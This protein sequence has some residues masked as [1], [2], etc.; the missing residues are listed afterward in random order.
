MV[1]GW[2]AILL[3]SVAMLVVARLLPAA[4]TFPSF[5]NFVPNLAGIALVLALGLAT[6]PYSGVEVLALRPPHWR[7]FPPVAVSILGITL[8]SAEL[9]AWLQEILPAPPWVLD[10]YRRVLEYDTFTEFM[11]V[12]VFL[13][14]VAPLTEELLFR[15]LFLHRLTEGY[16]RRLGI[17]ASALCFGIFHVLPWQAVTAALVGIYLGWLVVRTRSIFPSIFA[18][19]L[20][21][22][23]PVVGSG[24]SSRFPALRRL[25]ADDTPSS[26][27]LP[28]SWIAA[29]L[30]FLAVGLLALGRL[31]T[32]AQEPPKS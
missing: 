31:E 15:G 1:V 18:H 13:V 4:S 16:G 8:L 26:S 24:L 20:F 25:S 12:F 2:L 21:N 22:L 7:V 3:A 19:A 5:L 23:V 27:H 30:F 10:L 32:P 17:A 14:V 29:S 9:D 28:A 6:S 11:G